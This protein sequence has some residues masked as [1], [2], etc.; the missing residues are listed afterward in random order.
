[1]SGKKT[2]GIPGPKI[3]EKPRF[4]RETTGRMA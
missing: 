3:A 1:M 2:D 4:F